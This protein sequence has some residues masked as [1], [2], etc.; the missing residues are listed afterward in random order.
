MHA[1]HT[2]VLA[3]ARK[4]Y[5]SLPSCSCRSCL[6]RQARKYWTTHGAFPYPPT[7]YSIYF[8]FHLCRRNQVRPRKLV[9]LA[10][11]M[12]LDRASSANKS[13]LT[14]P[15]PENYLRLVWLRVHSDLSSAPSAPPMSPFAK[16]V[17][18]PTRYW[19]P[20]RR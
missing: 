3:A 12:P 20:V 9:R 8:S 1:I 17:L 7:S 18:P 11:R 14:C 19:L 4:R 13:S 2:G 10:L 15:H 16:L 6:I 5:R